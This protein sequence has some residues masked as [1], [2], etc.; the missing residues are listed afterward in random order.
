MP[1]YQD[2]LSE[3]LYDEAFIIRPLRDIDNALDYEAMLDRAS[4][5]EWMADGNPFTLDINRQNILHH[6]KDHAERKALT[7][8]VMNPAE[9]RC[10]GCVYVY[11]LWDGVEFTSGDSADFDEA[12]I[13]RFW[14]RDSAI[15]AD[16]DVGV[17]EVLDLWLR[18]W[19]M[20]K[21][22]YF[23]IDADDHRQR[24]LTERYK[25]TLAATLNDRGHARQLYK[26]VPRR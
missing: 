12:S 20:Q 18:T 4:T 26:F 13:L 5:R 3:E 16:L 17:I 1:L 9:S 25:L 10:F 21:P 6:I 22:I 15:E 23:M 8:T 7:F 11:P 14:L 19:Q 2:V 24:Y